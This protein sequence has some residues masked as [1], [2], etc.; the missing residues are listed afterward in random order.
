MKDGDYLVLV[1]S[2]TSFGPVRINLLLQYFGSAKKIWTSTEKELL[3]INLGDKLVTKFV[4]YRK[5]F[6][7]KNYFNELK[8]LKIYCL[9]KTDKNYPTNLKQIE[10]APVIL[11][12]KGNINILNERSVSIVGTRKITSYGREVTEIFCEGLVRSGISIVSGL[13]RGVDTIAHKSTLR[14]NGTTIAVLANGLDTVYP[15]ENKILAQEIVQNGGCL[16]SEYPLGY[17]AFPANFINRNRII[18]GITDCILVVE[19]AEKSGT[20]VTAGHAAE[21]SKTVFAVPGQIT[22]PMSQ[23]PLYLIKN[24]AKIATSPKDILDELGWQEIIERKSIE[25]ILP[26]GE[27]EEKILTILESEPLHLDEIARISSLD[28]GIVS[29]RLTIMEMKGLIKNLGGGSYRKI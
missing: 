15:P 26:E 29:A 19:G 11:Y 25:K 28:T 4:Q 14:F 20:L 3:K 18:S 2:F 24:G 12:A 6:D 8:R 13:A 17:P 1:S 27:D 21:Q 23:A 22:S 10:N 7:I 16:L 5:N 9:N